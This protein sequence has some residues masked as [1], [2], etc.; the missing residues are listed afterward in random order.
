[1]SSPAGFTSDTE[2]YRDFNVRFGSFDGVGFPLQASSTQGEGAGFF[3]VPACV[4]ALIG[5][6]DLDLDRIR[7]RGITLFHALLR[8]EIAELY[9]RCRGEGRVR[10]ILQINPRNHGGT[11]LWQLPWEWLCTEDHRFLCLDTEHHLLRYLNLPRP[12]PHIDIPERLRILFLAASPE[13]FVSL[14]LEQEQRMLLQAVAGL[15]QI[16]VTC[17]LNPTRQ[18][19]YKT[20]QEEDFHIVHFAGHGVFH[21]KLGKGVLC[22]EDERRQVDYLSGEDLAAMFGSRRRHPRLVLLNAC[23]TASGGSAVVVLLP[24]WQGP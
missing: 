11:R 15:P 17:L 1:M 7:Q 22:L 20:L 18:T 23:E 14:D 16:K 5:E 4:E 24:M 2:P 13:L 6:D 8:G 21:P 12:S 10:I 3:S 19:L 9:H